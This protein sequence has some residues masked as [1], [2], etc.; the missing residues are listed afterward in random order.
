V[1]G[2][3]DVDDVCRPFRLCNPPKKSY[4]DNARVIVSRRI[5]TLYIAIAKI[6][7]VVVQFFDN[8][9]EMMDAMY[10]HPLK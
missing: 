1:V 2:I 10:Y 3:K 7:I 8:A 4:A 9:G 5:L 6:F